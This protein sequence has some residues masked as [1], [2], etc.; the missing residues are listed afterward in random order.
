LSQNTIKNICIILENYDGCEFD[1]RLTKDEVL[2]LCHDAWYQQKRVID[3]EFKYLQNILSLEQ[4]VNDPEVME[5]VNKFHKTLWIEIKEERN[6]NGKATDL[7]NEIIIDRIEKLLKASC[8]NL[9]NIYLI[10]F[11]ASILIKINKFKKLLIVPYYDCSSYGE[12]SWKRKIPFTKIGIYT[13]MLLP[14][15]YHIQKA[16]ESGFNG[17]LFPK[18]YLR[19]FISMFQPPLDN[20]LTFAG[21]DFILG[22]DADTFEEEQYFRKLVV[23]TNYNGVRLKSNY[24]KQPLIFHKCLLKENDQ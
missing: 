11:S 14:L 16:K 1:I 19:G 22:T 18:Q 7:Y 6:I 5:L 13:K 4:L 12:R 2:V 10:S 23:I 9:N 20:L 8:V 3:T 15:K 24:R 17:L 21:N